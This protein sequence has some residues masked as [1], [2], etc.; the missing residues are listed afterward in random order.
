MTKLNKEDKIQIA[1][2]LKFRCT[3]CKKVKEKWKMWTTDK[4]VR[5]SL[6]KSPICDECINMDCLGE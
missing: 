2:G 1:L 3:K 4:P 6:W 5:A